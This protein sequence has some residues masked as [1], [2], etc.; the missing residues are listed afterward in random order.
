MAAQGQTKQPP[1]SPAQF[2]T[3]HWLPWRARRGSSRCAKPNLVAALAEI[4]EVCVG[5][6]IRRKAGLTAI[7]PAT[8]EPT[9]AAVLKRAGPRQS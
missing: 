9:A 8:R 2:T 6:R 1:A 4:E 7:G 5:L 3:V